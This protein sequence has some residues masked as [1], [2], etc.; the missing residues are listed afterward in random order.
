MKIT[1]IVRLRRRIRKICHVCLISI[2]GAGVVSAQQL[3]SDESEDTDK[4]VVKLSAFQVESTQGG[5]YLSHHATSGFRS[6]KELLDIPQAITVVPRDL[7]DDIGQFRNEVDIVKYAAAGISAE[8]KG[9]QPHMRGFRS[10]VLLEDGVWDGTFN[11]ADSAI[12]DSY[13]VLRGPAAVLYGGRPTLAG[14]IMR[15]TKKP[16][17]TAAYSV[18]AIVGSDKFYRGE[19]DATGPITDSL[20]GTNAKLS[21][22]FVAAIQRDKGFPTG[23]KDD[24]DGFYPSLQVDFPNTVLRVQA[25]ISEQ[26]TAGAPLNFFTPD[27]SNLYVGS[28]RGRNQLWKEE[29]SSADFSRNKIRFDAEHKFNDNWNAHAVYFHSLY[30]RKDRD[31][32]PAGNP[33]FTTR[34]WGQQ[35]FFNGA[36]SK[37]NL[38]SLDLVGK[39][40]L[41]GVSHE[42][43]LGLYADRLTY[44]GYRSWYPLRSISIDNPVFD[45]VRPSVPAGASDWGYQNLGDTGHVSY[46]HTL[47]FFEKKLALVAG[48]GR[49]YVNNRSYDLPSGALNREQY[50]RE[51][52]HRYGVVYRPMKSLSFFA[53]NSSTFLPQTNR[54]YLGNYLP[55]TE[56]EVVDIGV[57]FNTADE[58]FVGTVTY[59]DLTASNIRTQDFDHPGFWL[60]SGTQ[61]NKGYEIELAFKPTENSQIIAT[62]YKGDIKDEK[63]GVRLNNSVNQTSSL[64]AK[65][66]FDSGLTIGATMYH[67][68]FRLQSGTVGW[69]AWTVWNA[70]ATYKVNERLNLALNV[71]N[72]NDELYSPGG[73]NV[74]AYSNIGARRN[75][76]LTATYRF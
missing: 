8:H 58:R 69:P 4:K 27:V 36:E 38:F 66:D 50:V 37:H 22:R 59:F 39:Y 32:R 51:T 73:F 34:M 33:N 5:G 26:R 7:I 24:R 64:I 9:N 48:L 54:D 72:L 30:D 19:F 20:F 60:A 18:R 6:R 62:Y 31:V 43:F 44:E 68:G 2:I 14:I 10:N 71:E 46:S 76:K 11:N 57:K 41:F 52:T 21:Y 75:A 28:D 17:M 12:A 65:Y 74:T 16:Q 47:N 49:N 25:E 42:S 53:N 29:W 1:P 55:S 67:Q 35:F 56:G 23:D 40:E 3:D 61:N 70:F 13:E 45:R 63:T 15:T